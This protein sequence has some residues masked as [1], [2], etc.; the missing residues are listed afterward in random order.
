M[1]SLVW[2]LIVFFPLDMGQSNLYFL[3]NK[4]D[5]IKNKIPVIITVGPGRNIKYL[6]TRIPIVIIAAPKTTLMAKNDF[7]LHAKFRAETAGKIIKAPIRSEPISFMP[8]VMPMA[9]S[10]RKPR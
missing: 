10:K 7:M 6:A 3:V 9:K 2:K 5:A 1:P 8:K 4:S